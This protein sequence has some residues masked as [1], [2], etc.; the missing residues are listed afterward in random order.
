MYFEGDQSTFKLVNCHYARDMVSVYAKNTIIEKAD[1]KTFQ[2]VSWQWQR[3]A[4]HYYNKGRLVSI[5]DYDSFQVLEANYSKDYKNV[6]FYDK[7]IEGA[8]P[9]YLKVIR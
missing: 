6:F 9:A 2:L 4:Y 7:I 1:P 5:I 3:D 8:N